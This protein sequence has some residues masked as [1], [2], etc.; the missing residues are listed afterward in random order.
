MIPLYVQNKSEPI[1]NKWIQI[2]NT[3][4]TQHDSNTGIIVANKWLHRTL[5]SNSLLQAKTINSTKLE[6]LK[7]NISNSGFISKTE[8]GQEYMEYTLANTKI[9]K[10][11]DIYPIELIQK[12]SDYINSGNVLVGDIDHEEYNKWIASGLPEDQIIENIKKKPGIAKAIQS[13]IE[14]GALKIRTFIDKRYKK[15]VS[16]ANGVSLEA[17]ITRNGSGKIVD[18][19]LLGFTFGINQPVAI[20]V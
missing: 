8:D 6:I 5:T 15:L 10:E 12:W 4:S 20:N 16:A 13:F 1:R 18:G 3:I 11:G 7:F 14:N 17:I 9:D 2:N 19:N